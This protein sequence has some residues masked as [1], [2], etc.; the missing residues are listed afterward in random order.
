MNKSYLVTVIIPTRNRQIFAY[1]CVKYII[2]LDLNIQII[3][4]DNS[5]D[6]Q[7]RELLSAFSDSEELKYIYSPN[8]IACIDNY[9]LA[10]SM[11]SGEFLCAIGDDDTVLPC[12]IDVAVWMKK[13]N[14]DAVKYSTNLN[15]WWPQ[16]DTGFFD[17]KRRGCVWCGD[18]NAVARKLDTLQGVIDLLKNGCQNYSDFDLVKSYHGLVKTS[19]MVEIKRRSNRF[20]GGCSPD[21]YSSV[22]LSLLEDICC[23]EIGLPFTLPGVCY[24]STSSDS[25]KGKHSGE[26]KNA[27]QFIG[28]SEPYKWDNEIPPYYTVQT[29][30]AETAIKAIK[31][32]HREELISQYFNKSRLYEEM[33]SK[34]PMH[35]KQIIDL[36][37]DGYL[38]YSNNCD[39]K[40]DSRL[41]KFFRRI[42]KLMKKQIMV[43]TGCHTIGVAANYVWLF[44]KRKY[45]RI[46]ESTDLF[47]N[48]SDV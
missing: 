44:L 22:C 33:L 10:A 41:K 18:V 6:E 3:V 27:P 47:I 17:K 7:L 4:T 34:N 15:Y 20:Y 2:S 29:I 5:D 31:S 16:K 32:M 42:K 35:R 8:Q 28:M 30:W 13:N 12:I 40:R 26:L 24:L 48:I 43:K 39:C 46:N 25:E 37:G 1:E 45:K 21:I 14:I 23:Y 38:F 11:A 19:K 9:E 36:I